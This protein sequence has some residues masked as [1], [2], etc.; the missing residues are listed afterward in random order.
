MGEAHRRIA[1]ALPKDSFYH[2]VESDNYF[3]EVWRFLARR[4][5][6]AAA[7]KTE[8]GEQQ[9]LVVAKR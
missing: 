5:G 3:R 9:T 7:K 8:S 1:A 4:D 6:G 2:A